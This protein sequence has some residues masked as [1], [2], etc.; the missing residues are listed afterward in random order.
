MIRDLLDGVTL[1]EG[2]GY[3]LAAVALVGIVW[4]VASFYILAFS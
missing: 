2:V 3:L 4:L 1:L